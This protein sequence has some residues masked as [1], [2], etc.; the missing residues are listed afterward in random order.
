MPAFVE[1]AVFIV[2]VELAELPEVN[3]RNVGVRVEFRPEEVDALRVTLPVKPRLLRVILAVADP[4]AS[5]V[6]GDVKILVI[7]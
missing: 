3:R 5:N 4:P 6:V 1:V 2:S 7:V